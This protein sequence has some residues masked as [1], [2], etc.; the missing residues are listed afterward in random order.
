MKTKYL[1]LIIFVFAVL[2]LGCVDKYDKSK[3]QQP[4]IPEET[5]STTYTEQ[6]ITIPPSL[7]KYYGKDPVFLY[8]MFELGGA[9]MGLIANLQQ[10]DT[11][12]VKTSFD[13]FS[14]SYSEISG[15]VPEWDKYF[16]KEAVNKLGIAID[17]GNPAEIYPAIDNIGKACITCHKEVKPHIWAKYHWKDF[18]TITMATGNPQEP[19]LP[20]AITKLKYLTPAFDGTITN[21][22]EKQKKDASESWNQFNTLFSNMEKAC[23][24]CHTEPP[25]YFVSQDIKSLI[26]KAGQQ[27]TAGELED[28]SNTMQQI[29]TESCYK[30]HIIHEPAQIIKESLEK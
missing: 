4:T 14:K 12:N 29:G 13:T 11:D 21:L 7:D 22:K 1:I 16:D 8:K 2:S 3:S 23:L 17:S 6:K 30:C 9:M 15:M 28:A 18:R 27:I 10:N 24:Q 25:R 20:F 5:V 19:E 26:S